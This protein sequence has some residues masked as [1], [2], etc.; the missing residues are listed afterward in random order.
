MGGRLVRDVIAGQAVVA[1]PRGATVVAAC[2]R[3]KDANV[4]ALIVT[5]NARLVGVFTERDAVQRVLAEGLDPETT[6][7]S[8]V[9]SWEIVTITANTS[10]AKALQIMHENNFR[11]VPVVDRL[12]TP[13]GMVSVR[14]ALDDEL[15]AFQDEFDP[16][17]PTSTEEVD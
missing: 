10:I 15:R 11:H 2:K 14:D 8:Q 4:G 1:L 6:P 17:N 3:M 7:V 13:I 16:L 9:M 12:G 5:D